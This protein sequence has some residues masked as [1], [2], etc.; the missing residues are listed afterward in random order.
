MPAKMT[1]DQIKNWSHRGS[2]L[3]SNIDELAEEQRHTG[4]SNCLIGFKG[5]VAFL[6]FHTAG[7]NPTVHL[8]N[9]LIFPFKLYIL[10]LRW[11]NVS[12]TSDLAQC[13]FSNLLCNKP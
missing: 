6:I 3:C 9:F 8:L 2:V 4:Q 7:R 11:C 12:T 10:Y 5:G 13:Q 1:P